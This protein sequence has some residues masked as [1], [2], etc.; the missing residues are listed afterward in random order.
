[1]LSSAYDSEQVHKGFKIIVPKK[2]DFG[3][4]VIDRHAEDEKKCALV[5]VDST[6]STVKEYTYRDLSRLSNQA[7][8]ALRS[9]GVKKG[10]RVFI[11][12]GR[13]H[14]WYFIL[15]ACHKIGAVVMTANACAGHP[16][17]VGH[18]IS[19]YEREGECEH[20]QPCKP[21]KG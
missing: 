5:W 17:A 19:H 16:F 21:C 8:N 3:F 14:E 11:M 7:A 6:G 13:V 12:L 18:R 9:L 1:M 15:I 4:D 2:F 10:D 20:H